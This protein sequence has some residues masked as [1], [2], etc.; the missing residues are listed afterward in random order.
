MSTTKDLKKKFRKSLKNLDKLNKKLLHQ[1]GGDE[2]CVTT[3]SEFVELDNFF[4]KSQK[5]P[6]INNRDKDTAQ[7]M[8]DLIKE[9]N[10]LKLHLQQ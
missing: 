7:Y 3:D 2:Y 9:N 4:G 8:D 10:H 1:D 6:I 5:D